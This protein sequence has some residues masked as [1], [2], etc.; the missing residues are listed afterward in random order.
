MT[1]SALPQENCHFWQSFFSRLPMI[2]V[3]RSE[4][5][6]LARVIFKQC[7]YL[8]IKAEAFLPTWRGHLFM[9]DEPFH[10]GL[11]IHT[12]RP[13]VALI[14]TVTLVL[15]DTSLFALQDSAQATPTAEAANV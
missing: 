6:N 11:L 12:M 4:A 2:M 9:K 3:A 15:G 13:L 8:G 14:C 1:E 5:Q 10:L 7:N